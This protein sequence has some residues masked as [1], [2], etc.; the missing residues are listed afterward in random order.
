MFTHV[1][2]TAKSDIGLVWLSVLNRCMWLNQRHL[3]HNYTRCTSANGGIQIIGVLLQ[4]GLYSMHHFEIRPLCRDAAISY[5]ILEMGI[6]PQSTHF[7][8][9]NSQFLWYCSVRDSPV[10]PVWF[11]G[12][13][14]WWARCVYRWSVS[15]SGKLLRREWTVWWVLKI[16]KLTLSNL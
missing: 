9:T 5:S 16:K 14:C 2:P 1:L 8:V 12:Q 6:I 13:V 3:A 15:V 4:F 10:S 7:C 11:R